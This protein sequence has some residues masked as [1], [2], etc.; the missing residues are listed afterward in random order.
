MLQGLKGKERAL[1]P[2][3][4]LANDADD[5]RATILSK[6]SARFNTG[7]IAII[8]HNAANLP[9]LQYQAGTDSFKECFAKEE[10]DP[11]V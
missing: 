5:H 9:T 1:N 4:V 8:N 6:Q 3:F 11:R 10:F 7:G 2:G